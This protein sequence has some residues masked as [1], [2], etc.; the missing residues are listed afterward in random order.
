M[1]SPYTYRTASFSSQNKLE[2]T[3]AFHSSFS[4]KEKDS[5]T[6]YY[7]FGARYYSSDLSLWLSVDPM[8]DK[9]PSLPPYNYCAWNPMKLVDPDGNKPRLRFYGDRSKPAFERIVNSGLGGQFHAN[10]TRNGNGSYTF[11]I[12]ATQGG[13]DTGKLTERQRAFYN[14]LENCINAK[15]QNGKELNYDIDVHYGSPYIMVGKYID[16]AIDVADMEQFN[17]LNKGG[18]TKQGKLVHEF[19]EQYKKAYFGNKKGEDMGWGYSHKFACKEEGLVNGNSRVIGGD[20]AIGRG[21]YQE[22]FMQNGKEHYIKIINTPII[23]VEQ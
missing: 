6:G 16:N 5:E 4:G 22:K 1:P 20:K 18:A 19:V 8:S 13:G 11:D 7:Y 14:A 12:V 9:Y 10:L 17:D 21:V 2:N 15:A 3:S 23:G